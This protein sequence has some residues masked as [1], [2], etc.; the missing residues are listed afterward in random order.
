MSEEIQSEVTSNPSEAGNSEN[1]VGQQIGEIN[2]TIQQ[3]GQNQVALQQMLA[4]QMQA[5]RQAEP[6]HEQ[7][8]TVSVPDQDLESLSRREFAEFIEGNLIKA[9]AENLKPVTDKISNVESSVNSRNLAQQVEV[10]KSKYKDFDN[11]SQDMLGLHKQHPTLNVD[12]LY[13]MAR[14][15]FPEKAIKEEP[16][17][18]PEAPKKPQFGGLF[19]SSAYSRDPEQKSNMTPKEAGEAA[20]AAIFGE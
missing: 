2:K 19:P 7:P 8:A 16:P 1:I 6:V 3:L 18:P 20:W 9:V 4:Q 5:P 10:A 17:P 13:V 12:Q 14:N 11:F 15:M